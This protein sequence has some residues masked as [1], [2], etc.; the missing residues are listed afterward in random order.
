VNLIKHKTT[1]FLTDFSEESNHALDFAVDICKKERSK[2]ILLNIVDAPF[3]L[4]TDEESSEIDNITMEM[5]SFSKSNL[6]KLKTE[7]VLENGIDVAIESDKG[8][9]T[10]VISQ[11]VIKHSADRIVMGAKTDKD[12]FFKTNSFVIVKNTSI[13]LL[14]ISLNS[15]ISSFKTI[16]FPFNEKFAT[17]KK[18]DEV[19]N[20]SKLY[21]SKV[22]LLG[23]SAGDT[24]EKRHFITNNMMHMKSILDERNVLCE[25]HFNSNISYSEA[26]LDYCKNHKV[27]LIAIAN[28][29]ANVLKETMIVNSVKSVINNAEIPVLTIPVR[30]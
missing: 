7:I 4:R 20:I 19:I 12:L 6:E 1:L 21:G 2:L 11:A 22:I 9:L 16:L 14:T 13:P 10:S 17:L 24:D 30:D 18:V 26:I 23:I 15:E 27:G 5:L 25:V 8:E 3:S 29:L 28:N